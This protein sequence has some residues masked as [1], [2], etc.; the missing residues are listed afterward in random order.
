MR[1]SLSSFRRFCL[2]CLFLAA[3]GDPAMFAFAQQAAAPVVVEE[4]VE[5]EVSAGQTFVGTVMPNRRSVVGS[6]V[7]GRV[8]E[9]FVEEGDWVTKDQPLAQLLT[10]TLA[11]E[12][13]GATAELNLRQ[14]EVEEMTNG[15]RPEEISQSKAQLAAAQALLEYAKSKFARTLGLSKS[16]SGGSVTQEELDQARSAATAAEQN[17]TAAKASYELVEQGPRKERVDQAKARAAGQQEMVNLLEDRLKKYTIR[18]P[19]DGYVVAKHTEVGQW[20]KSAEHVADGLEMDPVEVL[21]A[22]SESYIANLHAGLAAKQQ[23]GEALT[24]RVQV[25][26]VPSE[27]FT[28]T[29]YRIVPLADVRS[30]TFPVKLHLENP[31]RGDSHLLKAGM[32]ARVTLPVEKPVRATLVPKDAL[33]LGGPTPLVFVV[34]PDA[35][36]GAAV[37]QPVPVLLGVADG[38]LIQ[39]TGALKAGQ[40]VVIRG[41]ERLRPGQEVK[42]TTE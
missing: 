38:S 25:E 7:D 22:V 41:N 18:A 14:H 4:V 28:G 9:M 36:G 15:S 23:A 1:V 12:I 35:K 27:T 37:A 3:S 10:K 2:G 17:V 42:I 8:I 19:F 11:I 30:R 21:V 6:A 33:V 32:I 26:A 34:L 29:V 20:V 13:A 24:A 16:G 5:R 31:K 40:K 39:V